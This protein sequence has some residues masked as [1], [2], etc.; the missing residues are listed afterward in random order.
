MQNGQSGAKAWVLVIV[1]PREAHGVRAVYR[2][3]QHGKGGHAPKSGRNPLITRQ[4]K[5]AATQWLAIRK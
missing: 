5:V 3:S 1:R 2:R 4:I